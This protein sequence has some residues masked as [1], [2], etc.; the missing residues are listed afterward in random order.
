MISI[1]L[2]MCALSGDFPTGDSFDDLPR[3]LVAEPASFEGEGHV[4]IDFD[5][6]EAGVHLGLVGYSTKFDAGPKMIAGISGR[7]P[8]PWFSRD[9]LGL[10]QD[11]FGAFLDFSV[12][13]LDRD[14]PTDDDTK[15]GVFLA[16]LG[17]DYT[18]VRNEE[19]LVQAQLGLQYG[20]FGGVDDV[21]NGVAIYLGFMAGYQ[22]SPGVWITANPQITFADAGNRLYF[23]NLGVLIAF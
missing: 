8:L 12:T 2:L 16:T 11:D 4:F 7:A 1:A 19:W 13:A 18:L 3:T 20:Y 10:D 17:M 14:R 5:H 22:V 6:F 15:G 21:D 23:F 9:L